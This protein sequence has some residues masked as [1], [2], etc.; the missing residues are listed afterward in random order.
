MNVLLADN[1]NGEKQAQRDTGRTSPFWKKS[2]F[3]I[4]TEPISGKKLE[5]NVASIPSIGHEI[6]NDESKNGAVAPRHAFRVHEI[7]L[8]RSGVDEQ[9]VTPGPNQCSPLQNSPIKICIFEK[10]LESHGIRYGGLR[11]RRHGER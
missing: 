10:T 7:R 11:N 8:H 1:V 6:R 3:N 5:S 4:L 9:G 2:K